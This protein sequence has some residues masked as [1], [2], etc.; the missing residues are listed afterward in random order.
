MLEKCRLL[1]F[2]FI[3]QPQSIYWCFFQGYLNFFLPRIFLPLSRGFAQGCFQ[4][5]KKKH[6]VPKWIFDFKIFILTTIK[7]N[8][9]WKCFLASLICRFDISLFTL[10]NKMA[11]TTTMS[12]LL[13][14]SSF[15]LQNTAQLLR[16]GVCFYIFRFIYQLRKQN[17]IS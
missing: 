14:F 11:I 4:G 17:K 5:K 6:I 3:K 13:N 2:D 10:Q 8:V 9:V 15:L 1:I 12:K 7:F 16:N